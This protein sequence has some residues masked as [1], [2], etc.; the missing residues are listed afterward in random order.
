MTP[1]QLLEAE[2]AKLKQDEEHLES[3][4]HHS[5]PAGKKLLAALKESILMAA[6]MAAR[7][8][9][10]KHVQEAAKLLAEENSES[11]AAAAELLNAGLKTP[12]ET[13]QLTEE[14]KQ[15]IRETAVNEY[16]N[17][18]KIYGWRRWI[19]EALLAYQP[20]TLQGATGERRRR[21]L[22][23][24]FEM[25]QMVSHGAS[26]GQAIEMKESCPGMKATGVK[27][28]FINDAVDIQAI[29]KAMQTA[30]D[31]GFPADGGTDKADGVDKED[32]MRLVHTALQW[33][34]ADASGNE[35]DRPFKPVEG[36][37]RVTTAAQ[38]PT[39]AGFTYQWH[40][41]WDTASNTLQVYPL[42]LPTILP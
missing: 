41:V 34:Y 42:E 14:E 18:L 13:P 31:Q 24:I 9:M 27:A 39:H 25:V 30:L 40:I 37:G 28:R 3:M 20:N 32:I 2:E 19:K 33:S 12:E 26:V 21:I 5:G 11:T 10:L 7:K 15:E 35:H 16:L 6:D 36:L 17:G 8:T 1:Q 29:V 38:L 4:K 23:A 22:K